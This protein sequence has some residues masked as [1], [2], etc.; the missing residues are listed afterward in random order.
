MSDKKNILL[1]EDDQNLAFVVKDNL[2]EAGYKV[3]HAADGDLAVQAYDEHR[4]DLILLDIMLP[5]QDGF[6][7]AS[8]IREKNKQTPIIFLT[9]KDFKDDRIKG[10]QLGADDYVTKPFV[11]EELMLRIEAILRR[12]TE[13]EEK[14][15]TY[16][17]G[18]FT[19]DPR[20]LELT[21]GETTSTLT[22]KEGALLSELV[23]H[24]DKV[25]DRSDLLKKV[26]G[27]DGYFVGRSMDVYMSK[28][29]KYL[30][31]DEHIE[32][33]NIH[34]VGFKLVVHKE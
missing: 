31:E 4:L 5:K 21:H 22:K 7:V 26:W 18:A 2:T 10:F 29:R 30:K 32:I 9:A 1:V 6:A 12:T 3:I 14:D 28:I 34:G 27:K 11:L 8:Y 23:K 16:H 13:E 17:F 24:R 25:V 33:V 15:V 20:S 19:F